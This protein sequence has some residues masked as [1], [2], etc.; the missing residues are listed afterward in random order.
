MTTLLV[1]AFLHDKLSW[2]KIVRIIALSYCLT[3][4]GVFLN[5]LCC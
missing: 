2:K 3:I 1:T 4:L 5:E